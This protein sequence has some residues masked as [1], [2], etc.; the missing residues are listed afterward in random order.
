LIQEDDHLLTVLRYLEANPLR[1]GM[2][3]SACKRDQLRRGEIGE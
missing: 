2:W 1:A 3:Q